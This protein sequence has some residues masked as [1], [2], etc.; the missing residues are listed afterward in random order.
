MQR[1]ASFLGIFVL[2]TAT[3][4]HQAAAQQQAQAPPAASV[5][6]GTVIDV[7]TQEPLAKV[8]LRMVADEPQGVQIY[9]VQT[10][11]EG[12]FSIRE[13]VPG[14]YWMGVY[15]NGFVFADRTAGGSIQRGGVIDVGPGQ[16]LDDLVLGMQAAAVITG[17]V[18][19]EDGE[20]EEG[21]TVEAVRF[22]SFGGA[23]ELLAEGHTLTNDNGEYRI[24]GLAQGGY[25]V[26]VNLNS[27]NGGESKRG[28][29][30]Q[31][32]GYV[33]TYYPNVH[34]AAQASLLRI[35]SK[36]EATCIDFQMVRTKTLS[37]SGQIVDG[38]GQPATGGSLALLDRSKADQR[39]RPRRMVVRRGGKFEA[40]GLVPGSYRLE[41]MVSSRDGSDFALYDFELADRSIENLVIPAQPT[42]RAVGSVV[43][44]GDYDKEASPS[45]ALA[46]LEPA[47]VHDMRVSL[48]RG[49]PNDQIV[50][51]GLAP[52]SYRV[53]GPQLDSLYL[54][55]A[56]YNGR[57]AMAEA[58]R[59][60]DGGGE[61]E[62]VLS[63]NG[64][65][66]DGQVVRDGEGISGAWVALIPEVTQRNDLRKFAS[67][68]QYGVFAFSGIAPGRYKI[69]AWE[70]MEA[71]F[72]RDP[73]VLAEV[74]D[75]GVR[76][77]LKE[78][79]AKR[80]TPKLIE[81]EQ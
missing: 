33:D 72:G 40:A 71:S 37:M 80:V 61:F 47:G 18:L 59:V 41:A 75:Q 21:L 20:P 19:D 12:K 10:D 76:V 64:A 4:A 65:R 51:T 11:A 45:Q 81:S 52:D 74:A 3:V 34:D 7:T 38:T 42:F 49:N 48:G 32:S 31:H 25:Y 13:I 16:T 69:F 68:D 30:G 44:E 54:K 67:T 39:S 56:T 63:A 26:R 22:R 14:R 58:V 28:L 60:E 24:Y 36:A 50:F 62:I 9:T 53:R 66:V 73:K 46:V 8:L 27:T 15:R 79:D 70:N 1:L 77:E 55:S 6:S 43:I 29:F 5:V 17:R 57:D 2:T 35:T 23:R 78:G